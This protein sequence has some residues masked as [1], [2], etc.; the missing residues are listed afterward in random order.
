MS[1]LLCTHTNPR[2][3]GDQLSSPAL[4]DARF[5]S[6]PHCNIEEIGS[7]DLTSYDGIIFAGG[8]MLYGESASRMHH[9]ATR[10]PTI[11]IGCGLNESYDTPVEWPGWLHRCLYA[12]L[13][14]WGSPFSWCPCFSCLHPAFDNV[15]ESSQHPAV[16]YGHE[17]SLRPRTEPSLT[18][19]KHPLE[20]AAILGYLNSASTVITDS[21]HGAFWSLCLGRHVCIEQPRSNKFKLL[22]P[23]GTGL[24]AAART[25]CRTT[26]DK[27]HSLTST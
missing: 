20:F 13:R 21:Y 14:D 19:N 27:V 16:W 15:P 1:W 4:Y 18:H 9:V 10:H 26:L 7:L 6:L 5:A 2:N 17:V 8:G 23:P 3:L 25:C 11:V 24:L 12:A 22:P